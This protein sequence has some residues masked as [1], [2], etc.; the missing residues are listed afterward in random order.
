MKNSRKKSQFMIIDYLLKLER[1]LTF[2]RE[3]SVVGDRMKILVFP[4]FTSFW[5]PHSSI[6]TWV[7]SLGVPATKFGHVNLLI[8][9]YLESKTKIID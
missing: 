8:I 4:Y 2:S 1:K 7:P 5:K 3:K 9:L 6:S